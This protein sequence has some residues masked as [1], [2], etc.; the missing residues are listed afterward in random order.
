MKN[1]KIN[2][3]ILSREKDYSV[4]SL[5]KD[6]ILNKF[7][8]KWFG[9]KFVSGEIL[10]HDLN[11]DICSDIV[12]NSLGIPGVR[13]RLLCDSIEKSDII[14]SIYPYGIDVSA[15]IG[16]VFGMN[17]I[18]GEKK[19]KHIYMVYLSALSEDETGTSLV[20]YD[21]VG[22]FNRIA[23]NIKFQLDKLYNDSK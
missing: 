18:S 10:H 9:G 15:Y 16:Y 22:D 21:A 20:M 4:A 11:I 2:I 17:C 12:Q 3:L 5:F 1:K 6:F 14:V 8:H 19:S 7:Y 23:D 13:H